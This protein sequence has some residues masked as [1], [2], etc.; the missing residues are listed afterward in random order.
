MLAK[1]SR[2]LIDELRELSWL[3]LSLVG[4]S[5]V[6]VLFSAIIAMAIFE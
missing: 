2:W 3:L 4:L 1:N 6:C 5:I